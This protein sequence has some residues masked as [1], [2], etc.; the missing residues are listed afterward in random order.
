MR[1]HLLEYFSPIDFIK[2]VKNSFFS[3]N[4]K[5]KFNVGEEIVV[6]LFFKTIKFKDN[7]RVVVKK[8]IPGD[9]LKTHKNKVVVKIQS[10]QSKKIKFFKRLTEKNYKKV[11][12]RNFH[13]HAVSIKGSWTLANME[14]W[15]PCEIRDLGIGG[16]MLLGLS[17]PSPGSKLFLNLKIPADGKK[18]KISGEVVW[19]YREGSN[20][21]KMG[22]KFSALE[23][24]KKEVTLY[25][26]EFLKNV[27]IHRNVNGIPNEKK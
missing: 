17:V 25:L 2:T 16:A 22:L 4:T 13:R 14:L 11:C 3:F 20:K 27:E 6:D 15:H 8:Y 12:I 19:S 21:S 1:I 24:H 23:K 5:A 9:N 26:K 18:L 10:Y 7:L